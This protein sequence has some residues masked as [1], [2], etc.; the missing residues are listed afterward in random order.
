[1]KVYLAGGMRSNW[2]DQVIQRCP[3]IHFINPRM[4]GFKESE[5]YSLADNLGV[6]ISDIIFAYF[7]NDNP[8]GY[9]LCYEIGLM[10]GYGKRVIFVDESSNKY[11]ELLRRSVDF[12][13]KDFYVGISYLKKLNNFIE[14]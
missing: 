2:Q 10:K 1:M 9:G 11:M 6:Q 8:S 14:G 7:E 3:E 12:F 13:T 4:H 5:E